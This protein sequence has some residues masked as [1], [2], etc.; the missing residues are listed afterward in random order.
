MVPS[1][2][3]NGRSFRGAGAYH[4]HDKP[5]GTDA[6][7]R[8]SQRVAFTATRNLANAD[9]HAALDEMWRTAVDA[10]YL[11]AR[12]GLAP[13]GRKNDAPAKTVSLAW[14]PGQTPTREEMCA[15]ADS[16]LRTMG[17]AAHQA[18]YVAHNDTRH[19]HLHLIINRVHPDT[20]RALNDWQERKRAQRWALAYEKEQ[21]TVLC[22][23]RAPRHNAVKEA[24]PRATG[25]PHRLAKLLT[26]EDAA[27]RKQAVTKLRASF[28]PA[29]AAHYRRRHAVLR[30]F[31]RHRRG[32]ERR[33]ASLTRAGDA[34]GALKAL[35]GLEGRRQALLRSFRRERAAIARA[36][37]AALGH[38]LA[39]RQPPVST[40]ADQRQ[41]RASFVASRP[42]APG[43]DIAPSRAPLRDAARPSTTSFRFAA[44]RAG[45]PG[46][47][48]TPKAGCDP[49]A[50]LEAAPRETLRPPRSA[51]A[52]AAARARSEVDVLFAHR[53]AALQ[54]MPPQERAAAA[55]ALQAEQ[56]AALAGRTAELLGLLHQQ[57]RMDRIQLRARLIARRKALAVHRREASANAI[58]TMRA[59]RPVSAPA[60]SGPK[61]GGAPP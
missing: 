58:A 55:A 52:Q 61:P 38:W 60:R 48:A 13:T 10:L 19:P 16:F 46:G 5:D 36:Q 35:D 29:W 34:A 59:R 43:K 54:R 9:P 44:L 11:K 15:A 40:P 1:I 21:G 30:Q 6:R 28:R 33:A 42:A 49:P 23:A 17:W 2:S 20:G 8:T 47:N 45:A 31:D 57:R 50:A 12:S 37:H 3:R 4:L 41:D 56:A 22:P 53:W 51:S 14:A 7:P 26:N 39:D 18:L 25:V 32:V 27:S 24:I